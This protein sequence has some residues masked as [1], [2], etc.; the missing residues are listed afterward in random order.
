MLNRKNKDV[1]YEYNVVVRENKRKK[2]YCFHLKWNME[3]IVDRLSCSQKRKKKK[4]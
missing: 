3:K 1:V 2:I 4:T